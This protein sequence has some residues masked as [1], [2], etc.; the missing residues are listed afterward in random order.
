MMIRKLLL[1]LLFIFLIYILK[2][3]FGKKKT[4][5]NYSVIG[6][7]KR[8]KKINV[9]EEDIIEVSFK[10]KKEPQEGKEEKEKKESK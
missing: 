3:L 8:N 4:K 1:I 7:Q 5:K 9:F 6:N 2:E 10:E